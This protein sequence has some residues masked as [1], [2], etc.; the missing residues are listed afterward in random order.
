MEEKNEK[1]GTGV[2]CLLSYYI[3]YSY[4]QPRPKPICKG[5]KAGNP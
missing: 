3:A 1:P 4:D 5:V 2:T